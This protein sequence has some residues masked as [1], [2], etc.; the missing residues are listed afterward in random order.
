M[1]SQENTPG[2]DAKQAV[3]ARL[4]AERRRFRRV[5]VSATGRLYIPATLE[6]AVC[7]VVDISPGDASLHCKLL[8][9]PTGRAVIYLDTL[10]RFEGPIIRSKDD[11]FVMSFTCS[12]QKRE[13]LVDQLMLEMNRK[14]LTEADLRRFERVE[15]GV[16]SFT[17]FTRSNGEQVRCEVIDLSLNGVSV[18]TDQRPPPGEH[19]LIGHR[20]GRVARHHDD[21]VTIEF[22]GLTQTPDPA[23]TPSIIAPM[24]P[25]PSS[26]P[27]AAAPAKTARATRR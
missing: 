5:A 2:K 11:G 24:H 10:G 25:L 13:K 23:H 21:G 20:A 19:L 26:Q 12:P 17:H 18:R 1:S 7:T 4:G 16:G 9:E 14:I 6:E 8:Q 27:R 3:L 15:S 22:L